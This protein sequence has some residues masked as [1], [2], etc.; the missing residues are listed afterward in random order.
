MTLLFESFFYFLFTLTLGV[1]IG[2]QQN[3]YTTPESSPVTICVQ[4]TNGETAISVPFALSTSQTGTA[5]GTA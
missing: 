1:G 2:I 4:L 5:Q 3:S